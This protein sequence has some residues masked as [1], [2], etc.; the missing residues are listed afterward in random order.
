MFSVDVKDRKSDGAAMRARSIT[1][2][3][4]LLSAGGQ[5]SKRCPLVAAYAPMERE[6]PGSEKCLLF[7]ACFQEES[8]E[9]D[10]SHPPAQ[11]S[12]ILR[13]EEQEWIQ[14]KLLDLMEFLDVT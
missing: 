1:N 10:A 6:E 3:P 14:G 8:P 9:K 11:R 12:H 5:A 4:A 7:Y 13:L 2:I